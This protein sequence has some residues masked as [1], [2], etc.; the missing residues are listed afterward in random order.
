MRFA[1]C[2]EVFFVFFWWLDFRFQIGLHHVCSFLC[3]YKETNQ[4]KS[5]GDYRPLHSQIKHGVWL[6]V[7]LRLTIYGVCGYFLSVVV[8]SPNASLRSGERPPILGRTATYL[9]AVF[10]GGFT[11]CSLYL[12][13]LPFLY[14]LGGF[15]RFASLAQVFFV[16]V[17]S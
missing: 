14:L 5:A 13:D 12:V 17:D 16:T 10:L 9:F 4:R 1:L 15:S 6:F 11:F 7:V 2:D 8:C 3:R